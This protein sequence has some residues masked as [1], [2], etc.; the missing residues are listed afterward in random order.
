M[1]IYTKFDV[2]SVQVTEASGINILCFVHYLLQ[3]YDILNSPL[4][5]RPW[6][7]VNISCATPQLV[8]NL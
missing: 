1:G 6:G 4:W 5:N 8:A 3:W 2:S 7:N